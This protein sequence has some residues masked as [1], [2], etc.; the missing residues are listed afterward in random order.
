MNTP[1]H[2]HRSGGKQSKTY[3]AW[4]DMRKRCL[5]EKC[6]AYK[7]YGGRGIGV[8]SDWSRFQV[9]LN[10][11]GVAPEGLTLERIDVNKDYSRDNC[12][13]ATVKSQ[14]NNKRT[15]ILI[16]DGIETCTLSQ[17]CDKLDLKYSRIWQ[18]L[19][20]SK[21]TVAKAIGSEY[22]YVKE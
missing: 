15:S 12:E 13:W 7:D 16:T 21:W 6:H 20:K 10:D 8:C 19:V 18:R 5:N 9:F 1:K 17:L 4:A 11:M 2:G 22:S 14:N 3:S